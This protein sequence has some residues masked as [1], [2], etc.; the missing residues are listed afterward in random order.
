M[1]YNKYEF[2]EAVDDSQIAYLDCVKDGY[3]A[4]YTGKKDQVPPTLEET[5][6]ASMGEEDFKQALKRAQLVAIE[7]GKPADQ[8]SIVDI[9]KFSNTISREDK[10]RIQELNPKSFS[11]KIKDIYDTN[12]LNGFYSCCIEKDDGEICLAFRGSENCKIKQNFIHDWCE[13]DLAL[14]QNEETIQ[15]KEI[16]YMLRYYKDLG[17]LD[18]AKSIT[19]AGHSLGGNLATHCAVL[20][21]L[22]EYK[23]YLPKLKNAY[24]LDGPGFSNKYLAKHK[25]LIKKVT[26][27]EEGKS[28]GLVKHAKWSLVGDLLNDLSY[29]EGEEEV[30]AEDAAFLK[31]NEDKLSSFM[32]FRHRGKCSLIHLVELVK[33]QLCRHT[34]ES[35]TPPFDKNNRMDTISWELEEGEQDPLSKMFGKLSRGVDKFVPELVTRS[36]G[37]VCTWIVEKVFIRPKDKDEVTPAITGVDVVP[38]GETTIPEVG[39]YHSIPTDFYDKNRETLDDPD[40][41]EM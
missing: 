12:D 24:N 21:G 36:V 8:L 34:T 11:Y 39:T 25:N 28:N 2:K 18:N 7:T 33:R 37:G 29:K 30:V 3:D 40:G 32:N 4:L 5:I 27:D 16:Y 10:R 19:T 35:V 23:E 17:V 14:L 6:L 26:L 41:P 9:V 13:G 15:Q 31:I 22:E 1:D 38:E 20:M